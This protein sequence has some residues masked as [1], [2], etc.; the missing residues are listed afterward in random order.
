MN[1]KEEFIYETK[2]LKDEIYNLRYS[3]IESFIIKLNNVVNNYVELCDK[4][5]EFIKCNE[6]SKNLDYDFDEVSFW[7]MND[8]H[9]FCKLEPISFSNLWDMVENIINKKN[10]GMLCPFKI[11]KD[12][13]IIQRGKNLVHIYFDEHHDDYEDALRAWKKEIYENE[14]IK[15]YFSPF[16]KMEGEE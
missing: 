6:K 4:Y 12:G 7:W 5:K 15:R 9:T 16:F 2:D 8:N 14:M 1:M 3:S 13:Q 10:S 11:L